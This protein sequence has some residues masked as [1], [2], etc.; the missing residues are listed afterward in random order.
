MHYG[1]LQ[2]KKRLL[3]WYE[4]LYPDDSKSQSKFLNN[5]FVGYE[6]L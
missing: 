1:A 2:S 5:F 4:I 6:I 3:L